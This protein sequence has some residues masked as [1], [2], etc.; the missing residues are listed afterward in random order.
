MKACEICL[1]V[2][3]FH[4]SY[5]SYLLI[6]LF[7]YLLIYFVIVFHRP[8]G[9]NYHHTHAGTGQQG[10]SLGIGRRGGRQTEGGIPLA[11]LRTTLLVTGRLGGVRGVMHGWVLF[12]SF[13]SVASSLCI[14][15]V[16]CLALSSRGSHYLLAER[17]LVPQ[18]PRK[19]SL[20]LV[21]S[22]GGCGWVWARA[23]VC[24][25]SVWKERVWC[26]NKIISGE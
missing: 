6:Y 14:S 7:S 15:L 13:L 10:V 21:V 4:V 3:I 9:D 1:N 5:C 24:H 22:V 8:N 12:L 26:Y 17:S 23:S 20:L 11:T 2:I 19:G 25:L 16:A 18:R